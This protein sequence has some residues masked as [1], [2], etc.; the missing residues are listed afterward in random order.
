MEGFITVLRFENHLGIGPYTDK[1][2]IRADFEQEVVD[3][4]NRPKADRMLEFL[5]HLHDVLWDHSGCPN[6]PVPF[7]PDEPWEELS[8]IEWDM[9][10]T[11]GFVGLDQ[12]TNWFDDE[13][14]ELL[15]AVGYQLVEYTVPADSVRIGRRQAC[16]RKGTASRRVVL[17]ESRLE[18]S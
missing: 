2:K 9:F 15:L 13:T 14:V 18:V 1:Y 3:G 17:S 8:A 16:F 12:V 10:P 7:E 5:R 6:H 4:S 11:C